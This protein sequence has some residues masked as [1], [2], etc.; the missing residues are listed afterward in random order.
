M[1]KGVPRSAFH[2][3]KIS[4]DDLRTFGFNSERPIIH[5]SHREV[6]RPHSGVDLGSLFQ[7]LWIP[8][9]A[10]AKLLIFPCLL[11]F[12]LTRRVRLTLTTRMVPC[13]MRERRDTPTE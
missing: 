12:Q 2:Y 11:P 13:I 7:R 4:H 9:C 8:F 1:A 10:F 3:L 6:F 5:L